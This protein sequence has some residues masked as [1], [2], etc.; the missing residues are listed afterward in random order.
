MSS[1]SHKS[2]SWFARFSTLTLALSQKARG[3]AAPQRRRHLG[4]TRAAVCELSRWRR[5]RCF[6][7]PCCRRSAASS[8]RICRAEL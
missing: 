5:G 2:S 7:P 3:L 6:R 4:Q 1:Q 8:T